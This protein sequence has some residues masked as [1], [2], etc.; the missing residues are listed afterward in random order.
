[1]TLSTLFTRCVRRDYITTPT[2][3]DYAFDLVSENLTIYLQDSD[4]AV[5]WLRNLNFPAAAYRRNG[6]TAWYAHRGFLKAWNSLIPYVQPQIDDPSVKK[7]TVVGYSHGA[8]LAVFC[9]EY[10][11]YRRPDLRETLTGYGF[12]CPRVLWGCVSEDV[13]ERWEHFTVIRNL[14]DIVT[15]VP[16]KLLGYR[17]VGTMMEIGE[18]GKYSA[19]DAHRAQNIRRELWAYENGEVTSRKMQGAAEKIAKKS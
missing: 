15:H 1:M 18:A 2:R 6:K 11:W 4:G 8:A 12:G 16:P 19:V 17:H 14:P 10:V 13:A 7:I 9:H 3:A 5:D